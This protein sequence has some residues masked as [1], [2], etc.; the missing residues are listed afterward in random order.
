MGMSRSRFGRH[1]EILSENYAPNTD[2]LCSLLNNLKLNCYK[3]SCTLEFLNN[4]ILEFYYN[5]LNLLAIKNN[6]NED[7]DSTL[8]TNNNSIFN[9]QNDNSSSFNSS[10]SFTKNSTLSE[11]SSLL[12]TSKMTPETSSSASSSCAPSSESLLSQSKTVILP[13]CVIIL[14]CVLFEINID[15][16]LLFNTTY[17]FK[18]NKIISDYEQFLHFTE[19]RLFQKKKLAPLLRIGLFI[20]IM[21]LLLESKII[22]EDLQDKRITDLMRSEFAP[23]RYDQNAGAT[24]TSNSSSSSFSTDFDKSNDA[25]SS[26]NDSFGQSN[27]VLIFTNIRYKETKKRT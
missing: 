16:Y 26:S 3:Q 22:K 14:F 2:S 7:E 19:E 9:S 18:I 8:E 20:K 23:F 5:S 11:L 10:S 1:T 6:Q 13:D 17:N 21:R 25:T 15:K 27:L 4:V 12:K 24:S